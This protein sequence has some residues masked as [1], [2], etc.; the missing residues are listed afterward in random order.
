MKKH[1]FPLLVIAGMWLACA[2]DN[3]VLRYDPT[4]KVRFVNADSLSKI[5]DSLSVNLDSISKLVDSLSVLSDSIR[6]LSDSVDVL[7]DSIANGRTDY[8]P[9][10]D[11]LLTYETDLEQ[12]KTGLDEQN[13]SLKN[14]NQK[15]VAVRNTIASGMVLVSGLTNAS[16]GRSLS[17]QDSATV[18]NL[19]LSMT[20]QESS[21][22]ITIAGQNYELDVRYD[23]REVT[24]EKRRIVL[25]PENIEITR[26]A[27]FDSLS[28]KTSNCE[29]ETPVTFYF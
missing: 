24:N 25:I 5:N 17:Y 14:V 10:R 23:L 4:V 22:V 16:N 1:V 28:C 21:Y 12:T 9:T 11:Q 7:N 6:V 2:E 13:D 20:G 27:G 19:P 18:Y 26:I 8:I 15:M 3:E 29:N